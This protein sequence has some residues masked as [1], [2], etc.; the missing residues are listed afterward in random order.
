M[1]ILQEFRDFAMRGN[2]VDMAVGIIIGGAFGTIVQSLVKDVIMPPIGLMLGG[3]DFSD[4]KI[5]LRSAAAG[6]EAVAISIGV[7]INNLVSFLIVAL[8]VFALVKT[9][10]EIR[11]RFEKE[12][13]AAPPAPTPSETYLKE[14][15]DALV[16]R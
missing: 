9:I 15:R 3:V 12:Q 14:I 8:A 2:V 13:P 6:Q 11:K 4:I 5:P 16:K 1:R 7:F 10:N